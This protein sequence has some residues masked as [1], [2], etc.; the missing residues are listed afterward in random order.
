MN[1]CVCLFVCVSVEMC[2]YVIVGRVKCEVDEGVDG[3]DGNC[4]DVRYAQQ[5]GQTC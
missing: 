1:V 2:M 5:H 4:L 3:S